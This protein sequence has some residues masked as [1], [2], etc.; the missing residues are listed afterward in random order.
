M[1]DLAL[2]GSTR[3]VRITESK[4]IERLEI[5]IQGQD[6]GGGFGYFRTLGLVDYQGAFK[7]WLR[8]FPRPTFLAALQGDRLVS[9]IYI[10]DWFEAARDG[11]PIH[12]L[13]SIESLPEMRS[14]KIGWRLM[15]L[16][17][18]FSPGYMIVKPM[19]K[20]AERFFRNAGYM[21]EEEFPRSPVDLSSHT[22]YL[23]LPPYKKY[24]LMGKMDAYF[25]KKSW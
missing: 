14:K 10:D 1:E 24:A 5:A 9:W 17:L 2:T 19:N 6:P 22:G 11:E 16:G 20:D 15:M 4:E 3:Y 13:R 23:I 12:V 25:E 7:A 18:R 8:R 21:G